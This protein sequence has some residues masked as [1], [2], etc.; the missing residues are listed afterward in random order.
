MLPDKV[1]RA[2]KHFGTWTS[3]GTTGLAAPGLHDEKKMGGAM[4]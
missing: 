3:P 4:Q 2:G 1:S